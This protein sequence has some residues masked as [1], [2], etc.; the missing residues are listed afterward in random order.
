MF[1]ARRA[2]AGALVSFVIAGG[3]IAVSSETASAA[4]PACYARR[5][6]GRVIMTGYG[7]LVCTRLG[8][9]NYKWL[10]VTAPTAA[11]AAVNTFQQDMLNAVN[12]QRA[13]AGVAPLR[14]CNVLVLQAQIHTADQAKMGVMSHTGSNGSTLQQRAVQSTYLAGAGAWSL[15]ENVA[16][17]YRDIPSVMTA[18]MNSPGHRANILQGGFSD[19]GFGLA[20]GAN[21]TYWTQDF[22]A[23]G[24][25]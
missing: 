17:G 2:I 21:G 15:G 1:S 5:H 16:F 22:G 24:H 7:P 8:P 6:V 14:L 12:A 3:A 20:Q 23:G 25:C 4:V 11:P 18:W 9:Y 10:P 19:V 13:A